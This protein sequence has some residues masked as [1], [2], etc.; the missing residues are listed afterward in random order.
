MK[1]DVLIVGAGPV[2]LTLGIILARAGVDFKIIDKETTWTHQS[3]AITLTARTLEHLHTLGIAQDLVQSGVPCAF[4]NYYYKA[5]YIGRAEINKLHSLYN[6]LLQIPQ[7]TITKLLNEHL[8]ELS[9]T[10]QRSVEF[11]SFVKE[12]GL[13]IC[14]LKNNK[15]GEITSLQTKFLIAC[16]GNRSRVRELEHVHFEGEVQGLTIL[17]ADVLMRNF[18]YAFNERH[19]FFMPGNSLF[20]VLP[21]E[22]IGNDYIYRVLT[23]Y[24]YKASYSEEEILSL[25]K[26]NFKSIGL[27]DIQLIKSIWTT[28]FNP[29]QF[30]VSCFYKDHVAYVGDAAHIQSPIGAQG[31][32]TGIQD[33]F[34]IGWKLIFNLKHRFN[35]SL[36]TTY[37]NER[38]LIAKNLLQ[39]NEY[40]RKK[41]FKRSPL[42]NLLN[43]GLKKLNIFN[44]INKK[45]IESASQLKL[46]YPFPDSKF[47]PNKYLLAGHRFPEHLIKLEGFTTLL[48]VIKPDIFLCVIFDGGT[49]VASDI[50][51]LSSLRPFMQVLVFKAANN[52]YPNVTAINDCAMKVHN[53][54]GIT[55]KTYCL[56]RPDTYIQL[57]S[58]GDQACNDVKQYFL[59]YL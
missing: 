56:I 57:V 47:N 42:L 6:F 58:T 36:L 41:F 52:A 35:E 51:S 3:R 8:N 16:D 45:E 54:F 9:V 15:T 46:F 53:C 2:G 17:M 40:L 26:D 33:A 34:N 38:H 50:E 31:L 10:V 43:L 23:I 25:L 59:Q 13:I 18:P 22:R 11:L 24:T 4:L 21:L 49:D 29:K 37:H 14:Q 5:H 32:N 7:P 12:D 44:S 55:E 48:D 30:V 28:N 39:Y 19:H 1:T 20:A 27:H